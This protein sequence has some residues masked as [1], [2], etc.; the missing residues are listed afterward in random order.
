M[1]NSYLSV[2]T[3]AQTIVI[4][5]KKTCSKMGLNPQLSWLT[6]VCLHG[7]DR[8]VPQLFFVFSLHLCLQHTIYQHPSV[9][10]SN[11]SYY[12]QVFMATFCHQFF[13]Q[14]SLHIS[15]LLQMHRMFQFCTYSQFHLIN[16]ST[17][18]IIINPGCQHRFL[19][20]LQCNCLF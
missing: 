11:Q 7:F 6:T 3:K 4:T 9:T 5:E 14:C 2:K 17:C 12:S 16:T 20:D 10:T 18:L 1:L 19:V 13:I 15:V 8:N